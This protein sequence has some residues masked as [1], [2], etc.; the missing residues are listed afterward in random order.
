ME[1]RIEVTF[2][3]TYVVVKYFDMRE[4]KR[5]NNKECYLKIVFSKSSVVDLNILK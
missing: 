4:K 1:Y 2:E 5:G 3:D